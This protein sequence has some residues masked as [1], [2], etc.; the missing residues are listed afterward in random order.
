MSY[1]AD[2]LGLTVTAIYH[3]FLPISPTYNGG[4]ALNS[5]SGKNLSG[6]TDIFGAGSET[7]DFDNQSI[8][9]TSICSDNDRGEFDNDG[10]SIASLNEEL[11]PLVPMTNSSSIHS[12][13]LAAPIR[14]SPAT[15]TATATTTTAA[16]VASWGN[17][18]PH[19]AIKEVRTQQCVSLSAYLESI[20]ALNSDESYELHEPSK[21]HRLPRSAKQKLEVP[22]FLP[23][24]IDEEH[25]SRA[26]PLLKEELV[27]LDRLVRY[28]P[29]CVSVFLDQKAVPSAHMAL[30]HAYMPMEGGISDINETALKLRPLPDHEAIEIARR[31]TAS[32]GNNISLHKKSALSTRHNVT[33]GRFVSAGMSYSSVLTNNAN[34][35][36]VSADA[37]ASGPPDTSHRSGHSSSSGGGGLGVAAIG[38][39]QRNHPIAQLTSTKDGNGA[40]SD[41]SS[42]PDTSHGWHLP[43]F[44]SVIGFR[45]ISAIMNG[46]VSSIVMRAEA[47]E[48]MGRDTFTGMKS[49]YNCDVL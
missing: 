27:R 40:D 19:W 49:V 9:K 5:T 33:A 39:L 25:A 14:S 37:S 2:I 3:T 42:R 11:P 46:I 24:I 4:S 41:A 21:D 18:L 16:L 7:T 26:L 44:D 47:G 38:A 43:K 12:L 1:T 23:L 48:K 10:D 17:E 31:A 13:S 30:M 45:V 35:S 34:P 6:G 8:T 36:Y 15:T 29:D 20:R 28:S 32:I 22:R